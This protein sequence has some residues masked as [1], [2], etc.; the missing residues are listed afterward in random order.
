MSWKFSWENR[1]TVL[2]KEISCFLKPLKWAAA[3]GFD[4]SVRSEETWK[5][6]STAVAHCCDNSETKDVCAAQHGTGTQYSCVR[7]HSTYEYMVLCG[8][9]IRDVVAD[10]M[11]TRRRIE[12]LQEKAKIPA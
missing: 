10:A 2:G 11:E 1:I 12:K 9:T 3:N 6:F 8:G 5:C 4:E 7:S